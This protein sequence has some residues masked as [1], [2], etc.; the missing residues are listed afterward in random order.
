[1]LVQTWPTL[2]TLGQH[3]S[4][5]GRIWRPTR[6]GALGELNSGRDRLIL[7]ESGS[8]STKSGTIWATSGPSSVNFDQDRPGQGPSLPDFD[9]IGPILGTCGPSSTKL[10]P[11]WVNAGPNELGQLQAESARD[12]PSL[13]RSRPILPRIRFRFGPNSANSE[14]TWAPI[15]QDWTGIDRCR[16]RSAWPDT[17][18]N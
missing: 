12:R 17:A 1:M 7:A 10:G 13:V 5:F 4:N 6:N 18:R 15:G 9:Q 14:Q 16:R 11:I 8:I 2:A 3:W